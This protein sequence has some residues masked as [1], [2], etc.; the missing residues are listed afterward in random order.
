MNGEKTE[1][2][3]ELIEY[4]FD[5]TKTVKLLDKFEGYLPQESVK[6]KR[7]VIKN[8]KY[9]DFYNDKWLGF[10]LVIERGCNQ[11]YVGGITF[12]E[13]KVQLVIFAGIF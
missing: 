3:D 5:T 9:T 7:L 11:E 4:L 10:H 12:T 8:Y 2:K 1:I 6:Y 13:L